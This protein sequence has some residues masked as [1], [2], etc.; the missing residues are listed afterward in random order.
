MIHR[1]IDASQP[2]AI[3]VKINCTKHFA[4]PGPD[5]EVGIDPEVRGV[6]EVDLPLVHR[7]GEGAPKLLVA[8]G[9][10]LH[11]VSLHCA[12]QSRCILKWN[13]ILFS[14]TY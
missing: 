10:V 12:S 6:L 9:S 14:I 2:T 4:Q 13:S 1:D 7:P 5:L 11:I 3:V 8:G